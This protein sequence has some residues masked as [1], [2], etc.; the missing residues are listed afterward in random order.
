MKKKSVY[1][2]SNAKFSRFYHS[3]D[4]IF[5]SHSFIISIIGNGSLK[6]Y[7]K[8]TLFLGYLMLCF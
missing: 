3:N 1:L 8:S 7:Q 4:E 5:D 6:I 2:T